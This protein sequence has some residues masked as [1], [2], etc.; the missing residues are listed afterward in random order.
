MKKNLILA[1]SLM[2]SGLLVSLTSYNVS[3]LELTDNSVHYYGTYSN[4]STY[5]VASNTWAYECAG[6]TA[7]FEA[8]RF[9]DNAATFPAGG[10]YIEI[11]LEIANWDGSAPL[12][13]GASSSGNINIVQEEQVSSTTRGNTTTRVYR[14]VGRWTG[15]TAITSSYPGI[16]LNTSYLGAWSHYKVQY[17]TLWQVVSPDASNSQVIDAIN[18]QSQSLSSINS[19][20]QSLNDS[21]DSLNDNEGRVADVA[22]DEYNQ[23]QEDRQNA[24]SDANG[25]SFNFSLPN[26][27]N[28][29]QVNDGCVNTP[30]IDSWLH[31]DGDWKSPH[32]PVFPSNVR[33]ALTPVLSLLISLACLMVVIRWVS[34]SSSDVA[35]GINTVVKSEKGGKS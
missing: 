17:F 29:F 2:L 12:W 19:G 16:I 10:Y 5:C 30:V 8:V 20:I 4:V 32:C 35:N 18:S 27:F 26:P 34:S 31:L 22:E 14:L 28:L 15:G 21:M 13:Y 25:F 9:Y 6:T 33:S 3:A 24:S 7:N 23:T 1:L 11:Y